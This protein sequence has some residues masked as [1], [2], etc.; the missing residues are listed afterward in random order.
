M[1]FQPACLSITYSSR[2]RGLSYFVKGV[3]EPR[4]RLSLLW[5]VTLVSCLSTGI[6]NWIS[7][8]RCW[9]RIVVSPF[10]SS[11]RCLMYQNSL[12]EG[13][14]RW[15]CIL[16]SI[17][18]KWWTAKKQEMENVRCRWSFRLESRM[19]MQTGERKEGQSLLGF[20]S[21]DSL[22][23]FSF[24]HS[25][26]LH[27]VLLSQQTWLSSCPFWLCVLELERK[28]EKESSSH[29]ISSLS[30]PPPLCVRCNPLNRQGE[31]SSLVSLLV[32]LLCVRDL[33]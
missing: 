30:L 15:K 33:L 26:A 27:L 9:W 10:S 19:H 18:A 5:N 12:F 24:N 29:P 2:E 4:M 23:I 7:S 16:Y 20:L 25:K 22:L 11:E 31:R 21:P 14:M 1:N 8:L 17:S 13:E 28:R 3:L 32:I 6:F